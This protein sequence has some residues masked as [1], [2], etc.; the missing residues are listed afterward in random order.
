MIPSGSSR[1]EPWGPTLLRVVVGFLFLMYGW[2]KF[3][4]L[5]FGFWRD[6]F[7]AQGI[8]LADLA[9]VVVAVTELAG[10]IALVL[11][12]FAR[13]AAALLAV[14][15]TVAALVVGLDGGFWVWNNGVSFPLALLAATLALVLTGPGEASLDGVLAR[16]R[17]SAMAP[18]K[19]GVE[20]TP[21]T[22]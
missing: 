11:G 2:D 20:T 22:A 3:F 16:R 6:L 17:G 10:G 14:D 1:I 7:A 19:A 5:G 8:P 15:M 4:G 21:T 12:L 18:A 13:L 9:A